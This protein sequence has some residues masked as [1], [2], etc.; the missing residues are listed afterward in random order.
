MEFFIDKVAQILEPIVGTDINELKGKLEIPQADGRGDIAMACFEYA[1]KIKKD[2]NVAAKEISKKI[3]DEELFDKVVAKG[4]FVNFYLNKSLLA[5]KI[6]SKIYDSKLEWTKSS[7]GMN[8]TVV[9]DFSSPNIAK[10]FGIGHLRSTN[11]GRALSNIHAEL[12]YKV[13][14]INHLGDWGT[15]FGKLITAYKRWGNAE[16][17]KD[18]TIKNLYKLY[19]RFHEEAPQDPTLLEEAKQWFAKLESGS[20]EAKE[21][22]EWF[23]DLSLVE[24]KKLYSKFDISFDHYTG[25]SFFND[26]LQGTL[27]RLEEKKLLVK[28]QDAWIID[29]EKFALGVSVIK[30]KDDTSLYITRDICAAE[31]RHEYFKFDRTLYIV[32]AP[33]SLHFKQLFKIL[34][35][36]GYE[37][38]ANCEH[39]PFG[40]ISFG[41]KGKA[42][43]TREGTIVFLED[44]LLRAVDLAKS[45]IDEKNPE[46]EGKD[47]IAEQVGIGAL[48]Y[49][50]LSSKRIKNVKFDWDDILNFDGETGPYLQYT[51]V[52]IKSLLRKFTGALPQNVDYS[53]LKNPEETELIKTLGRFPLVIRKAA[54]EREPFYIARY[55]IDVSKAF[56]RF[57]TAHKILD[58][59]ENVTG[60]RMVLSVCTGYVFEK[61]F[62]L[63]GIP[64]PEK[65]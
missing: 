12:G 1:K 36:L 13:V 25:E 63:L 37:W 7:E 48:I 41:E 38:S 40:H 58:S 15:Q 18:N 54:V 46:L 43:S 11:I 24:L 19:V 35:L 3:K 45:I 56:N 4:G 34:E 42:M 55:L 28:S 27:K 60:A 23:R 53:I 31:Y 59:E 9:F 52:R 14:K 5:S 62:A 65:M 8:K 51:N 57:Y 22:W 44:V 47:E 61:G 64:S 49:A 50:D 20:Q 6:I 29:L 21:L 33:Q 39:V 30:K 16:I 2:P 26:K 10:P 17:L 32:G